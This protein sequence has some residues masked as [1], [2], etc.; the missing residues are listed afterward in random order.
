[1][2]ESKKSIEMVKKK[3]RFQSKEP[4]AVKLSIDQFTK[5]ITIRKKIEPLQGTVQEN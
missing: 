5:R 4:Q 1:M 2:I 3:P